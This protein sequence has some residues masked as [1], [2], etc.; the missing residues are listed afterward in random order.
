[1]NAARQPL[2]VV[3]AGTRGVPARYGGFETAAEEIGARLA[4][5]GH[6]VTVYCRNPGQRLR[7]HRGMRLVNLPAVRRS[8]VDTLS[9]TGLSV[10]HMLREQPDVVVLFNAANAPFLPVL[11]AVGI[12]TAVHVDGLEWQRAKWQG[13]GQRYYRAAERWSVWLADAVVADSNGIRTHLRLSYGRDSIFIPYGAPIVHAGTARLGEFDLE[14]SGFHLVVARFE[15]ENHVRLIVEGFR[16]SRATRPLIVVGSAPYSTRYMGEVRNAGRADSRV[17][18]VGSVW[19]QELLNELYGNCLTYLHGHSVG[20]T[21][22]SL[23]RAMGAGA[24]VLAYD[25][26]FNREVAGETGRY[27]TKQEDVA[28]FVEHAERTPSVER[29]RGKSGRER[30]YDWDDV[31]GRYAELASSLV[32][33]GHKQLAPSRRRPSAIHGSAK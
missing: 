31:A 27:F 23:L 18:F 19:D 20:G 2:H 30:A 26:I 3:L 22:P 24:P 25:V 10:A 12:P 1:M 4:A 9:H 15:P 11:R 5:M 29:L 16:A 32:W 14:P 8:A 28:T 17:R 33:R 21:N 13:M 6:R 7:E